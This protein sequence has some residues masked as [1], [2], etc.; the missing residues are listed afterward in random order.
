MTSKLYVGSGAQLPI[1]KIFH[2]IGLLRSGAIEYYLGCNHADDGFEA[3]RGR[4]CLLQ[5][6]FRIHDNDTN[7]NEELDFL[8][9]TA[10]RTIDHYWQLKSQSTYNVPSH[11][12]VDFY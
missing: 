1:G 8:G 3:G 5:S 7:L 4:V 2:F 6:L 9:S 10:C 12:P 11:S